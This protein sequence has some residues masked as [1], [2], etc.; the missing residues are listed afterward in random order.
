M[1]RWFFIIL[2]FVLVLLVAGVIAVQVIFTTDIPRRLVLDA[3]EEQTGLR[4]D[5]A[6]LQTGWAGSTVLRDLTIGLPLERDPFVH[7][8]AMNITHTDLIRLVIFRNPCVETAIVQQP[9]VWL[10]QDSQGRWNVL[11]AAEIVQQRQAALPTQPGE[12]PP[13]PKLDITDANIDITDITGRNVVYG[14]LTFRG[15][16]IDALSWTFGLSLR[17]DVVA[18]GQLAPRAN[19]SHR[20]DFDFQDIDRL[21]APWVD[22]APPVLQ[23]AGSWRGQVIDAALDGV[24]AM[25]PLRADTFTMQGETAIGVH[26]MN[27]NLRP[28]NVLLAFDDPELPAARVRG[29]T[30]VVDIAGESISV[31]RILL[32][33]LDMA[34]QIDG[35]WIHAQDAAWADVKWSGGVGEFGGQQA[36]KINA[37]LEMPRV[38]W[39]T[40]T[41]NVQSHGTLPGA[42]W[43]SHWDISGQG[44]TWREVSGSVQSPRLMVYRDEAAIDLS[45]LAARFTS[46][47]PL[48]H[49][50]H[51]D[52]PDAHARGR[53]QYN[54]ETGMWSLNVSGRQWQVPGLQFAGIVADDTQAPPVDLHLQATGTHSQ[55]NLDRL[56]VTSQGNGYVPAFEFSVGGAYLLK[57][58]QPLQARATLRTFI[59]QHDIDGGIDADVVLTGNVHPLDLDMVGSVRGTQLAWEGRPLEDVLVP[60][61]G[62]IRPEHATFETADFAML[63]GTWQAHGRYDT[64]SRYAE[65][66]LNGRDASL[67]RIIRL[68]DA[69]V[70]LTGTVVAD[71]HVQLPQLDPRELR[72]SGQWELAGLEGEG[73]RAATGRGDVDFFDNIV[74]LENLHLHQNDGALTGRAELDLRRIRQLLADVD[75]HGWSVSLPEHDVYAKLHGKAR[76]DVDMIDMVA[77]EGSTLALRADVMYQ[78]DPLGEMRVEAS[79]AERTAVVDRLVVTGAAGR[80]EGTGVV[81]LTKDEWYTSVLDLAWWDIDLSQLPIALDDEHELIGTATGT[82]R[83]ARS[84]DPRAPEP[85]Q[86]D[87]NYSLHDAAYGPFTLGDGQVTGFLGTRRFMIQQS[88]FALMDGSVD[89]WG[90]ISEHER[91]PFTH[92]HLHLRDIDLQQIADYLG[93]TEYPMPGRISGQGAAGGYLRA[94]HRLFGQANLALANSDI[95]S[96]PGIAQLYS[97]FNV[98]FRRPEPTGSGEMLVR[99]ENNS[100]NI[101]RLTYFNRGIDIVARARVADI[102]LGPDSPIDGIAAGTV[103][104]LRDTRLPFIGDELDRLLSAI[105]ADAATVRINGTV[106]DAE[107]SFVPLAEVSGAL[108]RILSGRVD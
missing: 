2:I 8:P 74:R 104:P 98:D 6:S 107:T 90:R 78:G 103:R 86:V 55:I 58:D 1:R 30:L 46:R 12:M 69:P 27:V 50:T 91:Q 66:T 29:G 63:D 10:R 4:F 102:W 24:L 100:L 43:E 45:G 80:A 42:S 73:L 105:Q 52:L 85:M 72:L 9:Q 26:G 67:D 40:L 44:E 97:A 95:V 62:A 65:A 56:H 41:A 83:I 13:L 33:A 57:G 31:K 38:G 17:G 48:V 22:E 28:S 101:A 37:R 71:V 70:K 82:L 18:R 61:R 89:L 68:I 79:L 75:V 34:A 106:S 54:A 77:S 84:D 35:G 60:M 47:W 59:D 7:V 51:L 15:E 3:L 93:Y 99:L 16:P 49:L 53:G 39:H 32:D 19:W 25:H 81:H 23:A 14:P 87:L 92:V 11:E 20:I 36:G 76:L 108:R 21:V 94:P 88:N 64:Q 5:A 96:A